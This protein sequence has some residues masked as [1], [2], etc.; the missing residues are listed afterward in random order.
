[1]STFTTLQ[2]GQ[3]CSASTTNLQ[4]KDIE[5]LVGVCVDRV[6]SADRYETK[7]HQASVKQQ[8]QL[9]FIQSRGLLLITA[10]LNTK[11]TLL[12]DWLKNAVVE[13]DSERPPGAPRH[14]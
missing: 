12:R 14:R 9:M 5:M 13:E 1:V 6:L 2:C 10:L 3:A 4:Y 11:G 8:I 7:K